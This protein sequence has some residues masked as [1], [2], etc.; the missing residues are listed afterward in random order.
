MKKFIPAQLPAIR[1]VP[2]E[3]VMN[4]PVI[5]A[6]MPPKATSRPLTAIVMSWSGRTK[7]PQ[8]GIDSR[9]ITVI[10]TN[11]RAARRPV[12]ATA[13]RKNIPTKAA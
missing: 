13:Q 3:I 8:S 5:S 4:S 1:N 11:V 7:R 12:T 10:G 6:S 2:T 9:N